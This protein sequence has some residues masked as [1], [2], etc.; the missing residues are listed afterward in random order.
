MAGKNYKGQ[1]A[2]TPGPSDLLARAASAQPLAGLGLAIPFRAWAP[3]ILL[4][5]SPEYA[6]EIADKA[7]HQN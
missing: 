5:F 3:D 1:P 2:N 7:N 4:R 6:H